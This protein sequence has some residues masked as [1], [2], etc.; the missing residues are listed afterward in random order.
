MIDIG[1][2]FPPFNL[3]NQEGKPVTLKSLA[4]NYNVIYFYPKDNTSGCSLEARGFSVLRDKFKEKGVSIVG[5]SPDNQ[6]SHEKFCQKND[7]T[8]TLLSD[9]EHTFLE[10]IGVWQKKKMCGR[11]YMGVVRTTF[12][13]DPKGKVAF[14]WSK[15]KPQGHAEEVYAKLTELQN[16]SK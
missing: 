11:E 2:K 9:T 15:V 12:L 6:A 10:K 7:L 1:E 8:I 5:I 3:P 4:G 14:V 13:I 16:A